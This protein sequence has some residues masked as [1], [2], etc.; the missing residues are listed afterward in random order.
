VINHLSVLS[1]RLDA[2]PRLKEQVRSSGFSGE[3][4]LLDER[5]FIA[6]S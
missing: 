2:I 1:P 6:L 5:E 4:W 3:C